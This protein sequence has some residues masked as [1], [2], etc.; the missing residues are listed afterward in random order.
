MNKLRALLAVLIL[1][2][3]S[4]TV[5]HMSG[6]T[7]TASDLQAAAQAHTAQQAISLLPSRP[8]TGGVTLAYVAH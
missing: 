7:T 8:A 2:G 5:R 6:A 4:A 1:I 3:I